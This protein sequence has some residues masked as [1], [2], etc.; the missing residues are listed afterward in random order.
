MANTDPLYIIHNDKSILIPAEIIS[1]YPNSPIYNYWKEYPGAEMKFE[2]LCKNLDCELNFDTF[3]EICDI[4]QG[5]HH[6]LDTNASIRNIMK[7]FNLIL[8]VTEHYYESILNDTKQHSDKINNLCFH[9][10]T[11][12][13]LDYSAY[14][15]YQKYLVDYQDIIPVQIIYHAEPSYEIQS[16]HIYNGLPIYYEAKLGQKC[17]LKDEIVGNETFLNVDYFRKQML[18]HLVKSVRAPVTYCPS[19]LSCR[20]DLDDYV[21]QYVIF[22]RECTRYGL[23]INTDACIIKNYFKLANLPQNRQYIPHNV[24]LKNMLDKIIKAAYIIPLPKTK[25]TF[26]QYTYAYVH[27]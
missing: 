2:D 16:I 7:K 13:C 21:N 11:F 15:S 23:A 12:L 25:Y 9:K 27:I 26:E 5:K 1:R 4:I 6:L 17:F 18:E 22:Y 14:R 10:N 8:P 20:L 19:M 3:V 24:D